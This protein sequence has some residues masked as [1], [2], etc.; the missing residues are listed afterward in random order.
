MVLHKNNIQR[1]CFG[2]A[3]ELDWMCAHRYSDS[4]PNRV[5]KLSI[6]ASIYLIWRER[7]RRQFQGVSVPAQTLGNQII[8]E[9]RG[10]LC[11]WRNVKNSN[12][13]SCYILES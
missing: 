8:E 5:Y 3:S 4:C 1:P 9:V 7:N 6:A 12:S 10:R 11:S 13:V 2:L